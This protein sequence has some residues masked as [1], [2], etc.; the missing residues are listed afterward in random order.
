MT[1]TPPPDAPKRIAFVSTRISGT[2]G[3]SMEI[4]K[5]ADVLERMGHECFYIAGQCDDRPR[6]RCE[7][8]PEAHFTHPVIADIN[9]RSFGMQTRHPEVSRQIRT[10]TQRI[11]EKL[12]QGLEDFGIDIIIAENCLTIPMN[13]P[14]GLALVETVMETGIGCIAHHHDF[15]WERERFMVNAVD[16][17][18][19]AAFPPHLNEIQH[20]AINSVAAAEF[21]RRTGLP[22]RVIPNVMDFA[23]PPAADKNAGAHFRRDI[24]LD[25]D[26]ILFLQPTRVVHR[27]GIETSVEL[28]RRL[29][30]PRCKL[31][32]THSSGDEGDAYARRVRSYAELLGVEIL[33]AE[34]WISDQPGVGTDGRRRY[35]VWD[36]YQAA[37]FVT[38][39][40][41]Y[42]GFGNAFLEAIYFGKPL[43]CNRYAIYRTDIEPCGFD[44]ILMDGFLTDEVVDQVREVLRD[45]R[46]RRNMVE[47][48][49]RIGRQFFSYDRVEHELCAIL[50]KPRLAV[51]ASHNS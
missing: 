23:S 43:L 35:T 10:M 21:S 40:S 42:E 31:V 19:Q 12:R 38:Y 25:A 11:D 50:N 47:Q 4:A 32:I 14:L 15:V 29:N 51:P 5:W 34:E 22:C 46:R 2:D 18:I 36:A 44:V 16:D 33:F 13:L 24:G 45:A 28:I 48:N 1:S 30:D 49:Y 37:D 39:P 7:V 8:I 17:H 6:D 26:D 9:R 27:K 20:V 41:T 3:V